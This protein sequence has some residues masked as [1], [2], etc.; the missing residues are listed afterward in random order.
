MQ[1]GAGEN[2]EIAA[3]SPPAELNLNRSA[4]APTNIADDSKMKRTCLTASIESEDST[5]RVIVLPGE[6]LI[7]ALQEE[8]SEPQKIAHIRQQRA[9][10]IRAMCMDS[11]YIPVRV[12]TKICIDMAAGLWA[13]YTSDA[14]RLLMG[15][16]ERKGGRSGQTEKE[17]TKCTVR[18]DK[19]QQVT[20]ALEV[21]QL[22]DQ[23]L[24]KTTN[25]TQPHHS[26]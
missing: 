18:R 17:Q 2:L 6:Q 10:R 1:M 8:L 13:S 24:Q 15:E 4:S 20:V 3:K 22:A 25:S 21:S 12:L 19:G 7:N 9:V 14:H 23:C 5:S 16:E 26:T 11:V